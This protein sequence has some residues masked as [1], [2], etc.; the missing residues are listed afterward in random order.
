MIAD[1]IK[2]LREQQ[3][4]TQTALAKRLGITR[5]GVNAWEM[6]ISVPSTQYI[7]AL[8]TIFGVSTDFLL[9]VDSTATL[10]VSGLSENDILAIHNL[11]EHLKSKNS[12]KYD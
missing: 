12:G 8:A 5:S 6:G 3:K 1:K 4:M 9:G 11:I 10:S 2:I 7:V